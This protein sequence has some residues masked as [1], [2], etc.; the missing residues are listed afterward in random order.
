M[1]K[2]TIKHIS[3]LL[4][5]GFRL[6]YVLL[7][8]LLCGGCI[9]QY[10]QDGEI[11]PVNVN[12]EVTL[13][14]E[15]IPLPVIAK[16]ALDIVPDGYLPR[17]IVEAR[18]MGETSPCARQVV[19][20]DAT[21]LL[22]TPDEAITLPV[23][24]SL[25]ALPHRLTVWADYVT[26]E[27]LADAHYNTADLRSISHILPYEDNYTRREAFFG[28]LDADLS[29]GGKP[30]MTLRIPLKRPLAH[31]RVVATDV[32]EFINKQQSNGRP[33]TGDYEVVVTYQ[34][35]LVTRMDATTGEL[36]D[37]GAGYSYTRRI[38][39]TGDLAECELGADYALAGEQESGVTLTVEVNDS[40]GNNLSR[41]GNLEIPYKRGCTTT[42]TG[43]FLTVKSG[44]DNPPGGG[45][46]VGFET[47][48]EGE[49]NIEAGGGGR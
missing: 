24:L 45:M 27:D 29:A 10:P 31:Y 32:Q 19:S 2:E 28:N 36:T 41:T 49:I 35:F 8:P 18:R 39:I 16:S 15:F 12:V 7:F 1:R 17:F 6:L 9:H 11:T 5:H 48:Y 42:V 46:D 14:R 37:S 13:D 20:V 3:A 44:G 43:A 30:E 26:R 23:S 22:K 21:E 25:D 33:G 47:D 4:Q 34:Y 38:H 40:E